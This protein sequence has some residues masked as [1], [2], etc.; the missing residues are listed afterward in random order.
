MDIL[1]GAEYVIANA[2]IELNKQG[3]DSIT[4]D[5][6]RSIGWQIQQCFN[7][8][9][10]NAIILTSGSRLKDAIYDFSDYFEY[11]ETDKHEPM[12]RVKKDIPIEDLEDRFI[13]CLPTKVANLFIEKMP[14][15][16]A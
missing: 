2:L 16:V 15:L 12:I 4:F 13:Y 11:A 10:I 9:G 3:H 14:E 1:V 7:K 6:L 8:E 5:K